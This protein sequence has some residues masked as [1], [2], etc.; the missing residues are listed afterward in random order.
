MK[1]CSLLFLNGYDRDDTHHGWI[2]LGLVCNGCVLSWGFDYVLMNSTFEKR[3][4]WA[5]VVGAWFPLGL[6]LQCIG[7]YLNGDSRKRRELG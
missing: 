4:A 2:R 1:T 5:F 7:M 6:S 3:Q